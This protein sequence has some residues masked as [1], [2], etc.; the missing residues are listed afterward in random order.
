MSMSSSN[1]PYVWM[2]F[3]QD[4]EH[5]NEKDFEE[6]EENLKRDEPFVIL[7]DTA[8]TEDH[9]HSPEDK[10]RTALWMKKNKAELRKLVLAMILIE[11][12]QA[13][14]LGIKAFSVLFTKF[15]GYP[16]ILASSR[17]EA[18]AI[19]EGLLSAHSTSS[20]AS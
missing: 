5:D 12:S 13:K 10:K 2:S 19:A 1:F 15:W 16:L 8:P 4:P 17:E 20:P 3:S 9:K 6:F 18:M 14:R 7:T 11:P